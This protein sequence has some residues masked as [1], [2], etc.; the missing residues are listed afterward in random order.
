V[1]SVVFV[2]GHMGSMTSLVLANVGVAY[3]TASS[4]V[5]DCVCMYWCVCMCV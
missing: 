4:G 5:C 1:L 2:L 3:G